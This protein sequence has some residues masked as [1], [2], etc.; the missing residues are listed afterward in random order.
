MSGLDNSQN[1]TD[2]VA[3]AKTNVPIDKH[4]DPDLAEEIQAKTEHTQDATPGPR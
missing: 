3:L 1:I 4:P 2:E